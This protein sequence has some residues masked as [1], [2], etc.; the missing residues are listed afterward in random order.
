MEWDFQTFQGLL[1]LN[2]QSFNFLE[3]IYPT[4]NQNASVDN[5]KFENR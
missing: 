1:V 3:I 5:L 4:F 2:I